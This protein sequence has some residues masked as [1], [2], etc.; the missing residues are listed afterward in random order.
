[1]QPKKRENMEDEVQKIISESFETILDGHFGTSIPGFEVQ[2][3]LINRVVKKYLGIFS[4]KKKQVPPSQLA[5]GLTMFWNV[6]FLSLK[7][8]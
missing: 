8:K 4:K 3:Y 1:M 2:W 5:N 7:N 6:N